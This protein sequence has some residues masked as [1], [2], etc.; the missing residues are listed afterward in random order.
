MTGPPPF[1]MDDDWADEIWYDA[2]DTHDEDDERHAVSEEP[3]F[4]VT[5]G[6][7]QTLKTQLARRF[8]DH[9]DAATTS[10]LS[11]AYLRSVASKP[12]SKDM[13]RRR[14][15]DYTLEK[16]IHVLEWRREMRASELESWIDACD[17]ADPAARLSSSS[18]S[19][20]DKDDTL[21]EARKLVE[22]LNTGSMYWH[23]LTREG[24]PVLWIRTQRK[25]WFPH[26]P[27]EVHALM[28]MADAG[29]VHGMSRDVTDFV[30]ISHSHK[31]P[32]PHPACVYQILRG[33][34]RGYPDRMHLLVSAPVS[35][36]IEFIMNLLVPLMPGRL[37]RKFCFHSLAHARDT[38]RT[39]LLHGEDDIPTF[40][41]GPV[42]H[43][44]Y[45][46]PEKNCP[47]RGQGTLKFDWY[48]MKRRLK[49]QRDA[50]EKNQRLKD[51]ATP[52]EP[53]NG[54]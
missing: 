23:G 3:A 15:L 28:V 37:A 2:L 34:V 20:D 42:D 8:P 41:G 27:A 43:D 50:F 17:T 21:T 40:F 10:F 35:S 24:R 31:P 44:A 30:C 26:V 25:F 53:F 12:Y 19:S 7:L 22:T 5:D 1:D 52:T 16:L 46:P 45:Y 13:T 33:L 11:D 6:E 51:D 54:K 36:V 18:S 48:G 49:E 47:N 32:P 4:R 14:P 39:L 29:I 9:D 38:L